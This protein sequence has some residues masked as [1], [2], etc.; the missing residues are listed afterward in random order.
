MLCLEFIELEKAF[1]INVVNLSCE[2]RN[3]VR[4]SQLFDLFTLSAHLFADDKQSSIVTE[5]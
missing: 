4:Q 5:S 2:R 1:Q 3:D